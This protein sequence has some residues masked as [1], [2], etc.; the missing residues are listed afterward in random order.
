MAQRNPDRQL[1]DARMAYVAAARRALHALEGFDCSGIA[2]DPGPGVE[3]LPWTRE[4]W[5][6][7]RRAAYA[8]AELV[9]RREEWDALRGEFRTWR[10]G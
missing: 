2:M 6:R 5:D 1:R 10:I 7:V 9:E 3:P 8:F 4:Q